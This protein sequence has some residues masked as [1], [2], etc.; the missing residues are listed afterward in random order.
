MAPDLLHES[1]RAEADQTL[2][3]RSGGN[4]IWC[5]QPRVNHKPFPE[6]STKFTM[7]G[8]SDIPNVRTFGKLVLDLRFFVG[9]HGHMLM[10]R[11]GEGIKEIPLDAESAEGLRSYFAGGAPASRTTDKHSRK[12]ENQ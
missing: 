5:Q 1:C 6:S 8:I 4:A 10:L 11:C 7:N 2:H 3:A 9:L 12:S